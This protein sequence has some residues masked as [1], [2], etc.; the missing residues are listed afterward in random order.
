M[1]NS[2]KSCIRFGI[3]QLVED[4]GN[5]I[6]ICVREL[7][8]KEV[9]REVKKRGRRGDDD[10]QYIELICPRGIV[11]IKSVI[12]ISGV[13]AIHINL[14][15]S[16]VTCRHSV[17]IGDM[18]RGWSRGKTM[19]VNLTERSNSRLPICPKQFPL[20]LNLEILIF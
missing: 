3:R 16:F 6:S 13:A 10:V 5:G 19:V 4:T 9:K 7:S 18:K 8:V 1:L 14:Q 20:T 12:H 2:K 15:D 11:S 17:T